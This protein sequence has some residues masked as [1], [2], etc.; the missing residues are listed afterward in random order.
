M[1]KNLTVI[2]MA[3][4]KDLSQWIFYILKAF[5]ETV[6]YWFVEVKILKVLSRQKGKSEVI[7]GE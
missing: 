4:N 7:G 5:L 2:I 3:S 1:M 6:F